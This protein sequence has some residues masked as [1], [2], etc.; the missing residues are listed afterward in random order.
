MLYCGGWKRNFSRTKNEY[1]A[2]AGTGKLL[3]PRIDSTFKALFTQKTKE[4]ADALRCFLSAATE[5]RIRGCTVTANDAPV[6]FA[7]Q[8]GVSYDIA[9]EL[10]DGTVADV[11]MQAFSNSMITADE[12]NTRL[13]GLRRHT[14]RKDRRGRRFP[15]ST[16]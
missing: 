8:R 16:R 13:P 12:P 3:N 1:A 11:E 4:S 2:Q 7:G 5:R 14:S 6:E 9:C 10:E 15:R